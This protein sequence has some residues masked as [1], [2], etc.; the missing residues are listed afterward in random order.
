MKFTSRDQDNDLNNGINC[1]G[2]LYGGWWYRRCGY[3]KLNGKPPHFNMN[4]NLEVVRPIFIE[5]KIRPKNCHI[6]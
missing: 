2:P 5:L 6:K 4:V 1:A 3:M